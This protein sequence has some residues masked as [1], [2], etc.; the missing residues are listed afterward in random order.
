MITI[1]KRKCSKVNCNELI[2]FNKRFCD[3]HE[4]LKNESR[5]QYDKRRYETDKDIRQTYNV[6][7]WKDVRKG[8]M[9]RD[10]S[11]CQYC[12]YR[13]SRYEVATCV[14][15]FIPIRDAYEL[16]YDQNN[17]VSACNKCNT[18]KAIDE[19][20]LRNKEITF[21]QFKERWAYEI[22]RGE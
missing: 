4:S 19:E 12:L 21:E 11:L 17:L 8:V 20:K 9:L 22:N 2:N 15:H 1:P 18:T 5:K 10:N 3:E 7:R 6:K 16:R 14:D 13:D